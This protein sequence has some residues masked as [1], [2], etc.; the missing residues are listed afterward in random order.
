MGLFHFQSPLF[1][2]IYV[3]ENCRRAIDK[4]AILN[5]FK[6]EIEGSWMFGIIQ[7]FEILEANLK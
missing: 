1:E 3:S 5:S 2:Q 6:Y 4:T 7:D